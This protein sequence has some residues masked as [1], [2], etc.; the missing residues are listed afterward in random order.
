MPRSQKHCPSGA[1]ASTWMFLPAQR[2]LIEDQGVVERGARIEQRTG[3]LVELGEQPRVLDAALVDTDAKTGRQPRGSAKALH[4][5]RVCQRRA[6]Q[7]PA[8]ELER[9]RPRNQLRRGRAA[10]VGAPGTA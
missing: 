5:A 1:K 4:H 8:M 6:D 3:V 2:R 7:L 9:R 10:R